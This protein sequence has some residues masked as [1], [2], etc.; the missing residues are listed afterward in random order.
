MTKYRIDWTPAL[1]QSAYGR[2]C[3]AVMSNKAE[4]PLPDGI[5]NWDYVYITAD[6]RESAM[7]DYRSRLIVS[8]RALHWEF[9]FGDRWLISA[10]LKQ[11]PGLCTASKNEIIEWHYIHVSQ[12]T[13][14][15]AIDRLMQA[16]CIAEV[17][18]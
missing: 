4:P 16:S 11:S 15:K 3:L 7:E 8:S 17:I 1:K 2:V 18:E 13:K 5:K 12:P 6:T 10:D 9:L 14:E